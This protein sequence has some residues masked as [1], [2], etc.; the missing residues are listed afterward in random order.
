MRSPKRRRQKK[1][2]KRNRWS[3]SYHIISVWNKTF[4]SW[5]FFNIQTVSTDFLF[6]FFIFCYDL[7]QSIRGPSSVHQRTLISPSEDLHFSI[8]GPSSV[9]QR[10]LIFPSEDLHLSIRGPSSVHQRTF[11]SPS[12]DLHAAARSCSVRWIGEGPFHDFKR[13][14]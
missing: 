9:H 8:R 1:E 12:E 13:W 5:F 3:W 14:W 11:I 6:L 10:T 4:N 7:H 2:Q